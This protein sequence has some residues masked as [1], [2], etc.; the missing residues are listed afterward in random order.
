MRIV[1]DSLYWI[2]IPHSISTSCNLI[3]FAFSI[4]KTS[5]Y[6]QSLFSFYYR[7]KVLIFPHWNLPC[8]FI[9]TIF[10]KNVKIRIS[11][12]MGVFSGMSMY[13]FIY[14]D[15]CISCTSNLLSWTIPPLLIV[16]WRKLEE[17]GGGSN[18]HWRKTIRRA[19]TREKREEKERWRACKLKESQ[20]NEPYPLG[21]PPWMQECCPF[22][23]DIRPSYSIPSSLCDDPAEMLNRLNQLLGEAAMQHLLNAAVDG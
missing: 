6:F 10:H 7:L 2:L 12:K 13:L 8:E 1:H 9:S 16:N 17:R 4:H 18:L 21:F 11:M 20:R 19:K 15:H 22:S 23:I 3:S 5:S 14:L